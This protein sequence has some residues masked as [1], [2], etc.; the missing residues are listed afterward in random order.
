MKRILTAD[1]LRADGTNLNNATIDKSLLNEP[2]KVVV[3]NYYN[4]PIEIQEKFANFVKTDLGFTNNVLVFFRPRFP[5]KVYRDSVYEVCRA[6][7]VK[8]YMELTTLDINVNFTS[9][10]PTSSASAV[11][12]IFSRYDAQLG[13]PYGAYEA[14]SGNGFSGV[15]GM[16][17]KYI[18]KIELKKNNKDD[19][20]KSK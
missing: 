12:L 15:K 14:F 5:N 2:V 10:F 4:V 17:K 18:D 13:K 8:S 3:K 6:A 9:L 11:N 7:N 16:F 1:S 19:K 20:K